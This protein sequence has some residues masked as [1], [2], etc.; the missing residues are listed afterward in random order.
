V[1][2]DGGFAVCSEDVN[3]LEY[4]FVYILDE[5]LDWFGED[6]AFRGGKTTVITCEVI[7]S[8]ST[9]CLLELAV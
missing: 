7:Y 9:F 5:F 4:L 3:G 1:G 8:L 6:L 2:F